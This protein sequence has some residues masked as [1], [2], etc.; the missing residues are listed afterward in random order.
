M[1]FVGTGGG[2][3]MEG[4]VSHI[5]SGNTGCLDPI[6]HQ[7]VLLLTQIVGHCSRQ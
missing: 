3:T 6:R 5:Q 1:V 2:L 7:T 4:Y